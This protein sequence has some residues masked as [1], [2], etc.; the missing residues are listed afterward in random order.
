MRHLRRD[1][2]VQLKG[3]KI[4]G[5]INLNGEYVTKGWQEQT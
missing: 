1:D 3:N 4:A 5:E 2:R